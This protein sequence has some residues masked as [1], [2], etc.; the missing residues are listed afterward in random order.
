DCVRVQSIAQS[1]IS[2]ECDLTNRAVRVPKRT[3]VKSA[4]FVATRENRCESFGTSIEEAPI[5]R[6]ETCPKC[7]SDQTRIV[8]QSGEPPILHRG[9][10][11]CA[12]V[13][14]RLLYDDDE[15]QPI[16][17]VPPADSS[18]VAR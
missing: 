7:G 3:V 18:A 8:G 11:R 16:I 15:L 4:L 14:S 17:V 10:Q 9:C 5:V 6:I 1:E 2:V 13:F 12:H